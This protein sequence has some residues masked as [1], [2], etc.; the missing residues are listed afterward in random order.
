VSVFTGL[1]L[2][3]ACY[4]KWMEFAGWLAYTPFIVATFYG[5]YLGT[6]FRTGQHF[7]T[8]SRITVYQAVAG[9]LVLPMLP[10][11]GYYGACLRTAINS[12][13]NLFLLHRWRPMRIQPRLD[14]PGFRDVI[15]IGLPLSGSGYLATSLWVSLEGSFMLMWFGIKLLGLYSMAVFV[16]TILTQMAQNLNQVMNVKVYEQ[17]GRSGQVG[18]C[19]KLILKPAALAFLASFP[20]IV[21]G[22]FAMPW[23]VS[24]LI[25]KYIAAVPMMRLTLL[26]LPISFLSLPTTILWATG[27]RLDCFASVIAGFGTFAAL[28]GIFH[29]INVGNLSILIAS[30]LGQAINI[31]VSYMLL[32]RLFLKQKQCLREGYPINVSLSTVK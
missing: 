11:L 27:R 30:A 3:A 32:W 8:L 12:I 31:F 24:L 6:T 22:W 17:Y 10:L 15:R 13:V 23:V 9:T 5:T 25:P 7:V 2:R 28:S 14:W 20:L 26:A 4:E 18:D 21:F 1:A 16:R 19:I 29:A